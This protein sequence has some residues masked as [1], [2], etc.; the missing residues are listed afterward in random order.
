METEGCRQELWETESCWSENLLSWIYIRGEQSPSF[1]ERVAVYVGLDCQS[2]NESHGN[3]QLSSSQ[4]IHQLLS[5][6]SNSLFPFL[7]RVFTSLWAVPMVQP[8]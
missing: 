6:F 1:H 5:S 4:E 2:G 7:S 3:D 8:S